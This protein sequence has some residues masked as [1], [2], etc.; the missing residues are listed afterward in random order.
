MLSTQVPTQSP[1]V[2]FKKLRY[3]QLRSAL[4]SFIAKY[5]DRMLNEE[6]LRPFSGTQWYDKVGMDELIKILDGKLEDS[7][8]FSAGRFILDLGAVPT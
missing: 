8:Q 2:W 4:T 6:I 5:G 3:A 1:Y 7:L